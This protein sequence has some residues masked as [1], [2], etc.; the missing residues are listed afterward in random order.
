MKRTAS[1]M[2]LLE[3]LLAIAVAGVITTAGLR[4][5]AILGDMLHRGN[6]SA[7]ERTHAS[8]LEARV[9]LAWDQR[10]SHSFQL[11]SWLVI[12]GAPGT[13]GGWAALH[14]LGMRTVEADG[15]VVWWELDTEAWGPLEVNAEAVGEWPPGMAPP[16]LRLRFPDA[17]SSA[18][19]DEFA[20]GE[21]FSSKKGRSP[22]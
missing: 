22:L 16:I 6:L 15:G 7:I 17:H 14:R 20:L 10:L 3:L 4:A 2:A 12:E 1:G 5:F 11:G 21:F 9:R 13:K 8:V 18:G 19:Q